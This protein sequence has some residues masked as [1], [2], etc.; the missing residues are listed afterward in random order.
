MMR[1]FDLSMRG[2]AADGAGLKAELLRAS[3]YLHRLAF[4]FLGILFL[5]KHLYRNERFFSIKGVR[6]PG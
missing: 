5:A 6:N 3:V 1:L 4:L 2:G